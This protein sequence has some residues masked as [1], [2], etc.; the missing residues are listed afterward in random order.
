[1]KLQPK[2]AY[3]AVGVSSFDSVEKAAD[4]V[5]ELVKS[6]VGLQ[7]IELLDEVMMSATNKQHKHNNNSKDANAEKP[8]LFLKF[9]GPTQD[10]VD[11]DIKLTKKILSNHNGSTPKFASSDREKEELWYARKVALWS[12]MELVPGE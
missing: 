10:Q 5:C 8:S 12:A 7:C 11:S 6:G 3:S 9:G 4:A 1:M 2:L